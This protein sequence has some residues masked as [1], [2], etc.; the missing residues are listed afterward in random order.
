MK[1][2][3]RNR[4]EAHAPVTN[5]LWMAYLVDICLTEVGDGRGGAGAI[6]VGWVGAMWRCRREGP[7]SA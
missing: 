7:G 2:A 5:V 4:W 3:T 6:R 1:K